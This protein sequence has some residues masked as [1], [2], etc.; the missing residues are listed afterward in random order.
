MAGSLAIEV[1]TLSK[2]YRYG[3]LSRKAFPAL[4]EVSF[5][6]PQGQ[7]F[8]LLGPNGAGKTT[9]IKVLLGIVRKSAGRVRLLGQPGGRR[10]SRHRIG[11]LPENLQVAGHHT[12]RSALQY[13][14]SLSG[15]KRKES[16]GRGDQ[17]LEMV[18]LRDWAGTPV[19]K[20]SKGMLQRLGLAQA[21]LHDPELLILDEPTD[22]LDPVGRNSIRELLLRLKAEGKT[23]FLNSHLLQEVE[24]VCDQVAILDSGR[25]R[26]VGSIDQVTAQVTSEEVEF[27]LA[28]PASEVRAALEHHQPDQLHQLG[29][30]RF[31]VH[32]QLAG[33][34]AIDDCVD[35]LRQH[36]VS[37]VRIA[38]RRATLE[39]AFLHLV[40]T[41][42]NATDKR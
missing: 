2:T 11:Y 31:R 22:G 3:L 10:A 17:L 41:T 40:E 19:R 28:A 25:L 15:L 14:G 5:V 34:A 39:D 9:V 8:G 16:R 37:I 42:G 21:L 24:L 27:E 12:A 23:I 13:Y 20:F 30:N 7:I 36:G 29:E 18:A 33:Q 38:H 32:L 26:F 6:V 35:N 4:S 1:D